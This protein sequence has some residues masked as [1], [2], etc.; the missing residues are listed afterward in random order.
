METKTTK[1]LIAEDELSL[2]TILKKLFLKKGFE[3]ETAGDGQVALAKLREESYDLAIVDIKMPSMSGLEVL[4]QLKQEKIKTSIIIMTAQD[5]MR[6]AVDAMKKGAYDYITKPFELDELEMIVDKVVESH[7]LA[8]EV[9]I[10]RQEVSGLKVDKE[11]KIVGQSRAVREVYKTIGKVAVNDVSIL[12]TGE[13]GTGKE[14]IAKAIHQNSPRVKGPFI[15]VNCAAIPRDLLESELFGYRKG[16]FTGAEE[17]RPGYFEIANQGT[18]FLDEVGDLP[19]NLQAKLL[20]VLQEK[21]VQRLGSSEAKSIDVRILA[22]TNQ[23]LEKMVKDKKFRE[24]LFFRLNVIPI[25]LPPLR[26]RK[27]DIPLLCEYFLSKLAMET[28]LSIKMLSPEAMQMLEQYRWPGNIRE[29]ENVIKR[30]AILSANETLH[31]Q[32]F[33]FFLGKGAE[34]TQREIEEMGLEELIASRLQSFLAKLGDVETTNLYE[35]IM[36]MAERPLIRLILKQTGYNQIRA[37]KILGINRNTLRKKIRS[38][39]IAVKEE[40]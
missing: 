16:A 4:D 3:V 40:L 12:I 33:A 37:A 18:L 10:L 15:A 19:L 11:A 8:E 35:T 22:A 20:R 23:N 32:D 7:R 24:D 9:Q 17:N 27:E 25:H 31:V 5:T 30:A 34:D 29:L 38:L 6:N 13:S 1:M 39:R 21:E 26:E 36:E 14:L 2:R 28:G